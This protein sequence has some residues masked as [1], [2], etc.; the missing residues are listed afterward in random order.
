[1][2]LYVNTCISLSSECVTS[3]L[4]AA[5]MRSVRVYM[6][7]CPLACSA[8]ECVMLWR[9]EGSCWKRRW[10]S[11]G[12]YQGSS[13]AA[14]PSSQRSSPGRRAAWPSPQP[15]PFICTHHTEGSRTAQWQYAVICWVTGA[16]HTRVRLVCSADSGWFCA[17][18]KSN[19]R[20]FWAMCFKIETVCM[21]AATKY[22]I[23]PSTCQLVLINLLFC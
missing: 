23:Y 13:T 12:E 15:Q 21:R 17:G 2:C 10:S 14:T 5:A 20:E 4:H 8:C 11:L 7:C 1:M 16:L 9:S 3:S 19:L 18:E 6:C 22:Y